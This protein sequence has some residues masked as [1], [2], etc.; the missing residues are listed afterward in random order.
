MQDAETLLAVQSDLRV[1]YSAILELPHQYRETIVLCSLE[2][3]SYQEAAAI[4]RCSE[5]TVASHLNRAK[6]LLTAKMRGP[7]ADEV[8]ASAT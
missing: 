8:N 7:Q 1:L 2:E 3:R 5:G 6:A 4:L